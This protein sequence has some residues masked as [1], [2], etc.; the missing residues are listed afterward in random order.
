MKLSYLGVGALSTPMIRNLAAAG[1]DLTVW[2]RTR[3]KADALDGVA[4]ADSAAEAAASPVVISC[5]ANDVALDAVFGDGTVFAAMPADAIHVAMSTCSPEMT[6][7]LAKLAGEHGVTHLT[8]AVLGRP[9]FV[10]RSAHRYLCSGPEAAMQTVRPVLDDVSERSFYLGEKPAAASV[11]KVCT[12]FL[13]ASAVETMAESLAL[14]SAAGANPEAIREMWNATLFP[15]AVHTG[16]SRQM[17]D[18][19][20]DPLFALRLMLK[21][22]GL[23]ADAAD[24][25]GLDAPLADSLR[26]RFKQA[27]HADLGGRDFTA[28]SELAWRQV[29]TAREEAKT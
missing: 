3:A 11:G 8:A 16:Y 18:R 29:D 26:S 14:A 17:L 19:E 4:V 21:D 15:G 6:T 25:N 22:V 9:D 20:F 27:V 10:E 12:N 23:F 28:I 5:L 1:H 2:N 7:R 24:A 13:I